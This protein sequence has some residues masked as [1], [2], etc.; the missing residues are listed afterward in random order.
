MR[1][2]AWDRD[3]ASLLLAE[4]RSQM[5]H[6][7]STIQ[8]LSLPCITRQMLPL[9]EMDQGMAVT[10]NSISVASVSMIPTLSFHLFLQPDRCFQNKKACSLSEHPSIQIKRDLQALHLEWES[11]NAAQTL[12][13][14]IV[15]LRAVYLQRLHWWYLCYCRQTRSVSSWESLA[16]NEK[17]GGGRTGAGLLFELG[18][19]FAGFDASSHSVCSWKAFAELLVAS[20]ET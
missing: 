12:G 19:S 10:R 18:A 11:T 2:F 17:N 16:V 15:L 13:I 5:S 8:S 6:F 20:R 9:M 14:L 1:G 7:G 3:K 4:D